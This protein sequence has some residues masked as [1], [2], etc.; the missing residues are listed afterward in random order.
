MVTTKPHAPQ[1]ADS[2]LAG[3]QKVVGKEGVLAFWKGNG[4]SVV[5]RCASNA[6][7]TSNART[8]VYLY[9]SLSLT[10]TPRGIRAACVPTRFCPIRWLTLS[11]KRL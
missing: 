8:A 10:A 9:I 2:L 3:L 7:R 11:H 5:H 4:T 1:Y 6:A